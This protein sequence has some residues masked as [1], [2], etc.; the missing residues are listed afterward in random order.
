M[1]CSLQQGHITPHLWPPFAHSF[2]YCCIHCTFTDEKYPSSCLLGL[3]ITCPLFLPTKGFSFLFSVQNLAM[4]QDSISVS[5]T[6]WRTPD[7]TGHQWPLPSRTYSDTLGLHPLFG[8]HHGVPCLCILIFNLDL[9]VLL[10]SW[11]SSK[12]AKISVDL[13]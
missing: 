8:P 6:L 13:Q 7:H 9:K 2:L 10:C 1:N 4:P 5:F 12:S 3:L 11:P